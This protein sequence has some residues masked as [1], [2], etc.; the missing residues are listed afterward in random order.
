MPVVL[1]WQ[2]TGM[3]CIRSHILFTCK[4][5]WPTKKK[6]PHRNWESQTPGIEVE[7]YKL[8]QRFK[9]WKKKLKSQPLLNLKRT[10]KP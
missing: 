7:K 10:I 8:N 2:A 3:I 9:I 4:D 5:Q 6:Q 1:H